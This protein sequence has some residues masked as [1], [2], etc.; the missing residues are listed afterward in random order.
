VTCAGTL[1]RRSPLPEYGKACDLRWRTARVS[2]SATDRDHGRAVTIAQ[3]GR[4]RGWTS[5]AT[6]AEG[7]SLGGSTPAARFGPRGYTHRGRCSTA[8][9]PGAGCPGEERPGH[10]AIEEAQLSTGSPCR[11][12]TRRTPSG[13]REG[14]PGDHRHRR[15]GG[16]PSWASRRKGTSTGEDELEVDDANFN[17]N[18]A[19]STSRRRAAITGS[20]P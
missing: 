4:C 10:A 16:A 2:T 7:R 14:R 9:A 1:R 3:A 11:S 17:L 5:S 8:C 18:Q 20:Q 12:G 19:G 13:M 6:S 15:T